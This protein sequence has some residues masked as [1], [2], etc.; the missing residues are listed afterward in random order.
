MLRAQTAFTQELDDPQA[1]AAEILSQLDL[2]ALPENNVGIVTFYQDAHE[3]G[4]LEA[5]TKALPF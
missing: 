2:A 3:T 5:I 4:V 1:A